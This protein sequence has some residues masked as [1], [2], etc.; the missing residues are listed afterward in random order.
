M[1]PQGRRDRRRLQGSR[2]RRQ[3]VSERSNCLL[4][5]FLLRRGSFLNYLID[6]ELSMPSSAATY[7]SAG[8][9]SPEPTAT[10][11][12]YSKFRARNS[13]NVSPM[14]KSAISPPSEGGTFSSGFPRCI[15]GATLRRY[16]LSVS[17]SDPRIKVAESVRPRQAASERLHPPQSDRGLIECRARATFLGS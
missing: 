3:E 16:P 1:R 9:S 6:L 15:R 7:C 14:L 17:A 10:R 12:K 11:E 8:S 13:G 2:R 5:V 4:G